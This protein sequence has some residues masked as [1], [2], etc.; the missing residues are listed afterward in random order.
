MKNWSI[1]KKLWFLSGALI[2]NLILQGAIGFY[3]EHLL[4]RS[5][6]NIATQQLPAVRLMTLADMMH[7]GLR[8]SAYRAI[9][10]SK[11]D[12]KSVKDEIRSDFEEMAK[13]FVSYLS[14]LQKL[15]LTQAT[16]DHVTK[17]LPHVNLYA[18][19]TKEIVTHSLAGRK[20][21]AEA[22]L[23]KFQETFSLLEEEMGALGENI[24]KGATDAEL[25]SRNLA[26]RSNAVQSVVILLGVLFGFFTAFWIIRDL[27]STVT[28]IM[29]GLNEQVTAVNSVSSEIKTS[30][31]SLSSATTEQAAA[32]QET[33]SSIE[34]MNAM[35]KKSSDNASKSREVSKVSQATAERGKQSVN[36][37]L[38]SIN[39]I[40]R[41]NENIMKA[42]EDSNR[43][44]GEIVQVITEI[45]TKT[46]VIND[47]V[48][49]TKLLSFN[50]S[51]E[52]AR[53]GEHGKGFAVVAEEVGNLAQM[54][55]NASKEIAEMLGGS[56]QKVESIVTNTKT[57]VERLVAESKTKVQEGSLVA[58]E[59]AE[60]LDDV[61]KNVSHVNE[62][63]G[64]IATASSEQSTG[65]SE[66][67][68]AMNQ[69]DQATHE[70]AATSQQSAVSAEN[71]TSQAQKLLGVLSTLRGLVEGSTH[72]DHS[73]RAPFSMAATKVDTPVTLRTFGEHA[74][75]PAFHAAKT[76][77]TKATRAK[78]V[79]ADDLPDDDDPRFQDI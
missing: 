68:K 53:A 2:I 23:P 58:K 33:A 13:Q 21:E 15:E 47:I 5:G 63:I 40:N 24:E 18:E 52:A 72:S 73:P 44:I 37:M 7:D 16:R 26:T 31:L 60:I 76:E 51:V 62:M 17:I 27:L 10:F 71:M 54:S 20:T 48:F 65:I 57:Q 61:V 28:S 75:P 14:D 30:S 6:E 35:V 36:A 11:S 74:N 66:I 29:S 12:D 59:C 49:Q 22:V 42:I 64:E 38:R 70:N 1:A 77:A 55:G 34:E 67:T 19:Q 39:D 43:Q 25:A 78:A 56:I 79:G 3:F 45:G 8:A 41:S 32:L 4:I 9:L 50:A 46:K 69:L